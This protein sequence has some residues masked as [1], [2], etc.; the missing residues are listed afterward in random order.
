MATTEGRDYGKWMILVLLVAVAASEVY[1]MRQNRQ[2]RRRVNA[3]DAVTN[4]MN[5]LRS[6]NERTLFEAS[7]S[8]H[9]RPFFEGA[10]APP[11]PLEVDLYFSLDRDCMS[12]IEDVVNQWNAALKS[13]NAKSFTVRGFTEI[14]GTR[15]QT[16]ID[17]DLKPAFPITNVPDIV[18]KLS[19]AGI[20]STPVAFVSDPSTGRILMAYAPLVGEKGDRSLVERLEAALT[21]CR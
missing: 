12:C 20:S 6:K 15:A 2:L 14:D 17:R 3:A 19:A 16:A 11:R 1:V 13:P 7:M 18:Q 8:G 9:C 4:R 21:P 10:S 5:F